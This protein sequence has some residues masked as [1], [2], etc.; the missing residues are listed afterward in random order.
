MS[1]TF[2]LVL[3]NVKITQLLPS[4]LS[5]SMSNTERWMNARIIKKTVR[6]IKKICIT[7]P[8]LMKS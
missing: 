3:S 6:I 8:K 2:K 1:K 5:L 7:E 4:Q